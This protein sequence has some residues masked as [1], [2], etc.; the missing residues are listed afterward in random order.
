MVVDH[1]AVAA[2]AR[3]PSAGQFKQEGRSEKEFEPVIVEP[4][5]E[6]MTDQPGRHRVEDLLQQEA[7]R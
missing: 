1:V 7:S 3:R 5:P 6:L 2:T 4:D